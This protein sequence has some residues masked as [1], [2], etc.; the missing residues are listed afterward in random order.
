M[1]VA[2]I[3]MAHT[4]PEQV[5]RLIRRLSAGDAATSFFIHVDRKSPRSVATELAEQIRSVPNCDFMRSRKVY[6]GHWSQIAVSIDGLG[7]IERSGH[8]PDQSVLVTGQHYPIRP[9]DE[10]MGRLADPGAAFIQCEPLPNDDWWPHQRGGLDRFERVWVRRPRMQM[11][12][13]PLVK[14][15]LPARY[16]PW[17]GSAYWSLGREHRKRMLEAIDERDLMRRFRHSLAGDEVFFQTV[18]MNSPLRESI[19]NDSLVFA[20]WKP[21]A[22]NPETLT[23]GDLEA[24]AGSDK[25]FARKIDARAD[26]ALPDAIDDRLA[27]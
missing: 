6:W 21:R 16:R 10:I 12:M 20:I 7:A 19:V 17:G 2:Y 22:N 26:P 14:K 15:Q 9:H 24:M 8:D 18:L 23:S 11:E 1:S 27:G 13:L 5:G 25:L 3:V 4:A